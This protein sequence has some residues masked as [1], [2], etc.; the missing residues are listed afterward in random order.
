VPPETVHAVKNVG[1]GSAAELASYVVERTSRSWWSSSQVARR[2]DPREVHMSTTVQT[3]ID[4]HPFQVDFPDEALDDLRRRIGA[5]RWPTKE[6]VDDHRPGSR[7][8]RLWK[9]G[10]S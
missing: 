5:A 4:V 8:L 7:L 1:S 6:L 2:L 3:G 9:K 10:G